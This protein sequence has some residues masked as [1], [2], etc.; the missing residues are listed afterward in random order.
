MLKRH[1]AEKL[2]RY[3]GL[4]GARGVK[5]VSRGGTWWAE[6]DAG[7]ALD[8]GG[9]LGEVDRFYRVP[10]VELLML[11]GGSL[12][13]EALRLLSYAG[14]HRGWS[15]MVEAAKAIGI[16]RKYSLLEREVAKVVEGI[17]VA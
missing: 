10:L 14:R 1:E 13:P 5:V 3:L 8:L 9:V 4:L 2:S 17:P 12:E 6:Q 11:A 16:L 7:Y 15:G